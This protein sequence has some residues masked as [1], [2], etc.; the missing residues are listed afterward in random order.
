MTARSKYHLRVNEWEKA[1]TDARTVL[2]ETSNTAQAY[3]SKVEGLF[4]LCCFEEVMGL[5]SHY[6]Q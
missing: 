4:N 5:L 2:E 1:V 3:L 6:D